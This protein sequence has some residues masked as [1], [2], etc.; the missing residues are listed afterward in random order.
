MSL[1]D[2]LLPLMAQA[3]RGGKRDGLFAVWLTLRVAL[4]QGLV[5]PIPARQA[6]RRIDALERR[7]TSLA[8]PPPLR[9]AIPGVLALLREGDAPSPALALQ[10]LVAP[11]RDVYGTEAGDVVARAAQVGRRGPGRRDSGRAAGR[12]GT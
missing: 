9:R 11:V 1:P 6:R 12:A 4:D 7:L 2:L 8:L 10:Q 3:P 5:P